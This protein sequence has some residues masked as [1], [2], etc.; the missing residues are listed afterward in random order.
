MRKVIVTGA[1]GFI[2]GALARKLLDQ[3]L[4]VY[5]IDVDLSMTA[6]LDQYENFI[7]VA[8][9]FSEYKML[10]QIIEE[11]NFDVCYHFAWQGVFGDSFK[12]YSLQL[13]NAKY[14]CEAL[15]AAQ[16]LNCGKFVMAGTY[17]EFEIKN[18]LNSDNFEPRYTCIYSTSKLAAE[19]ICKTLAYNNGIN[20]SAGL[21]CMAYGER[22]RSR[23]L[24]NVVINQLINN[25]SPK[26]IEGN[27]LYDM[28]YIDDIADAFIAIGE[29]GKNLKSYYVGH[30]KLKKFRELI[31]EMRDILNPNV[32]LNFG[33]F[34]DT[35]NM[36]YSLIDLD[37]LYNDTGFECKA[38]FRESILKTAQALR[39]T[40]GG[41]NPFLSNNVCPAAKAVAA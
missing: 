23:M 21:I 2:G 7:P 28:I 10:D 24:A 14:A 31:T 4:I 15:M 38:D 30:R 16:K 19:L 5:G 41:Y 18:F 39:D 34:K 32:E 13:D 26:L 20:Y 37:A 11:R 3:G 36:N 8:A 29:K 9:S 35:A 12:D 22:N 6:F 17:N 40:G 25:V 33:Q 27:N 1:G